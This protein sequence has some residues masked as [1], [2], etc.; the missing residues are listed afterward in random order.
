MK[1]WLVNSA[2][3]TPLD[4]GEV[5][6]RRNAI[7]ACR[8]VENGHDVLWWNA[9]FFH[10][11]KQHR[12]GHDHSV[13]IEPGYTIHF[14]HGP[15]YRKHISPARIR[16]HRIIGK[17]FQQEAEKAARPDIILCSCPTLELSLASVHYGQKH[18]IPVILDIRDIWPDVIIEHAPK[19][20]RPIASLL[21]THYRSMAN[22][23]CRGAFALTGNTPKFVEWGLQKANRAATEFDI[24]FPFGYEEPALSES[25]IHEVDDFWRSKGLPIDENKFIVTYI[26]MMGQNFQDRIIADAA[27]EVCKKHDTVF[28][29]CGGGDR[30]EQLRQTYADHPN[31]IL[32]GWVNAAQIWRLMKHTD[33]AIS[34]Y[35]ESENYRSSLTNKTIEYMAGGLP[36]LFSI[37]NGFVAD[38]I[39]N[40][41]IG[42]TYGGSSARLA[43]SINMLFDNESLRHEMGNNARK[44]FLE[45]YQSQTVYN[46][47]VKYLENIVE[48]YPDRQ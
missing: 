41:N 37:D 38:L 14:L 4:S 31:I 29:F 21:L 26:G 8:L 30:L 45:K 19:F 44:L 1:I 15:G 42:M 33:V 5:R 22:K 2:E 13:E 7:L 43:E 27:Q 20:L 3:G 23:A 35:Q 18:G 17:R 24:G 39:K 40:N 16:D 34:A 48:S 36:I 12:F 9:D 10:A 25:D 28:V 32:P 6:L 46:E 11:T 47:M